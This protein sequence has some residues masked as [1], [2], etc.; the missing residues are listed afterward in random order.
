MT[1]ICIGCNTHLVQGICFT[2]TKIIFDSTRIHT[3]V[4]GL[5]YVKRGVNL[6]AAV[7]DIKGIIDASQ[8]DP[9]EPRSDLA[10]GS[11]SRRRRRAS[12]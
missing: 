12:R 10:R 2:C 11:R 5:A 8:A 7:A 9:S 4:E 3:R 6:A 1:L